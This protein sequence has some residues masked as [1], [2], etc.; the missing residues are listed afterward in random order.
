MRSFSDSYVKSANKVYRRVGHLF[1]GNFEGREVDADEYLAHLVRYIHFNPVRGRLVTRPEDWKYSDYVEWCSD[2]GGMD[3][4]RKKVHTRL[5][6][7]S[8]ELEM[9]AKLEELLS[10]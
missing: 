2:S 5:F 9:R 7:N 4:A 8:E 1:Q 6:G 10:N 3:A